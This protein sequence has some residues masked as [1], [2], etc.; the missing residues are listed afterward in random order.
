M[1]EKQERFRIDPTRRAAHPARSRH[2]NRPRVVRLA[3]DCKAP[4]GR[5]VVQRPETRQGTRPE[6]HYRGLLIRGGGPNN[7]GLQF[8]CR[9]TLLPGLHW[10]R[11]G[12]RLP[13]REIRSPSGFDHTRRAAHRL[14]DGQGPVRFRDTDR[15]DG[16]T[17]F[18]CKD[19]Q[20]E[21]CR[22]TARNEATHENGIALPASALT[23]RAVLFNS[24]RV[25]VCNFALQVG[26]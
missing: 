8:R 20:L 16:P 1:V 23:F 15:P 3:S 7:V 5:G 13:G 6:L 14:L 18:R 19:A 9:S 22:T 26:E 24:T 21:G 10:L 25:T 17:G 2:T 11:F 4:N 12:I